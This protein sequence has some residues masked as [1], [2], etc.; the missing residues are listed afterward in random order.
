VST[1]PQQR[2]QQK[3]QQHLPLLSHGCIQQQQTQYYRKIDLHQWSSLF[4]W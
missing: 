4:L 2:Q 3:Q 1:Y